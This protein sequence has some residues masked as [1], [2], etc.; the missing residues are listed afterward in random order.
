VRTPRTVLLVSHEATRTGAPRIAVQ[1]ARSL[2]A[3]GYDVTTLLRWNGPLE[4]EMS[5]ASTRL[6]LEPLRRARAFV[7]M[8]FPGAAF[9][10]RLEEAEAL[11]TLLW[12]RPAAVYVNTVKSASYVRPARRLGIRVILHVHEVGALAERT[13]ARYRLQR[14][15]ERIELVACSRATA[16]ELAA[17]TGVD[18]GDIAVV[19]SLVDA[20]EVVARADQGPSPIVRCRAD[21]ILVGAC[22][23]A[24]E[25][26]GVD[27]WLQM[28]EVIRRIAPRGDLR[29]V[30][31]GAHDDGPVRTA[32]ELGVDDLVEFTGEL[33]NPLPAVAAFD[34]FTLP[35]RADPFPLAVLE[36]MALARPVVAFAVDGVPE[37][38][39]ETGVL[40]AP[41]DVLAL[42]EEV[43]S[44]AGDAARRQRLGRMGSQRVREH[45]GIARFDREV[46]AVMA[47]EG[48]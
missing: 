28:I 13:L 29:F 16:D 10:S 22:G 33:E 26:K 21:E 17:L 31:V 25:R 5:A 27:L 11:L 44:L 15:Y 8:H 41:E 36:A 20:D 40:V 37:Q 34:V 14:H 9:T 7:R 32:S 35:S 6:V 45:L 39:G 12:L 3:C 47:Q 38:V 1:L 46:C 48:R 19:P 42:A 30:W 23:M 43:V 4:Q 2:R 18:R 24:N